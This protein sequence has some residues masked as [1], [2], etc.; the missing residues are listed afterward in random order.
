MT[1]NRD[2][3]DVEMKEEKEVSEGGNAKELITQCGERAA[4]QRV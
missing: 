3:D 2:A 4:D 1:S